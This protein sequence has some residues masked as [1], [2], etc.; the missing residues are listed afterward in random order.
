MHKLEGVID[1]VLVV[2]NH[3]FAVAPENYIMALFT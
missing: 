1:K 2:Q 3:H